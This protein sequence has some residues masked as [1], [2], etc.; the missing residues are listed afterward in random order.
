LDFHFGSYIYPTFNVADS[1]ICIGVILYLWHS[2]IIS[3][4][5]AGKRSH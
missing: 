2:L 1:A 4:A 3:E 5:R